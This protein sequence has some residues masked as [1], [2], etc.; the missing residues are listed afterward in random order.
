MANDFIYVNGNKQYWVK[1]NNTHVCYVQANG[2]LVYDDTLKL[3]LPNPGTNATTINLQNFINSNNPHGRYCK[4]E[5]TNTHIQPHMTTGNLGSFTH[6]KFTNTSSGQIQGTSSI[7]DALTL[8]SKIQLDNQGWI[9]GAGG[10]GGRGGNSG[11]GGKGGT[12]GT[13]GRGGKGKDVTT[14]T[15]LIHKQEIDCVTPENLKAGW[16]VWDPGAAGYP[17]GAIGLNRSYGANAGR[18]VSNIDP[19][20]WYTMPNTPATSRF[21]QARNNSGTPYNCGFG[22]S[23]YY[24]L[25]ERKT[26]TVTGGAGGAGGRGASGG[27]GGASQAGGAGGAGQS[28]RN[29][30]PTA[31]TNGKVASGTNGTDPGVNGTVGSASSSP[32]GNSGGRGGDGGTGGKGGNS[33]AGGKGGTGGTWGNNGATGATGGNGIA[34]ATGATGG[35]GYTGAGGGS[36]GVGGSGGSAGTSGTSGAGGTGGTAGGRS[37]VGTRFLLSGS[38]QGNKNGA[39]AN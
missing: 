38:N 37:I 8:T 30:G 32:G 21:R 15:T 20:I 5:I 28:F 1:P 9:R 6:V 29:S 23:H 11:A 25:E 3:S 39:I 24:D 27:N 13:G 34:G 36:A 22:P 18:V 26:I 17:N 4:V 2:V 33:G 16:F 14:I 35:N 19:N 12:G 10:T 7:K 31:G